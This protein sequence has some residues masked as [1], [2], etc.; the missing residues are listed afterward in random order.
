MGAS[1]CCCADDEVENIPGYVSDSD[2]LSEDGKA[3]FLYQQNGATLPMQSTPKKRKSK[4]VQSPALTSIAKRA[5]YKRDAR[6]AIT[7]TE[8]EDLISRTKDNKFD[9]E[10]LEIIVS[11]IADNDRIITCKQCATLIRQITFSSLQLKLISLLLPHVVDLA[12]NKQLI[13]SQ[14]QF[15]KDKLHLKELINKHLDSGL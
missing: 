6:S 10:R 9:D 5:S 3:A 15:Y 8:L 7:D 12:E 14:I 11:T 1:F 13:I 4:A 2:V